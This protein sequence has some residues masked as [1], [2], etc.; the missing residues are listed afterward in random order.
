MGVNWKE[1]ERLARRCAD[2]RPAAAAPASAT[3]A[4]APAAARR[5]LPRLKKN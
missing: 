1:G 4:A 5:S 3:P 2:L